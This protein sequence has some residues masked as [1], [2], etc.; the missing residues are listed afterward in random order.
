MPG[1]SIIHPDSFGSLFAELNRRIE[2][3]ELTPSAGN[4]SIT[5][6]ALAVLNS[7]GTAETLVGQY[8]W[9]S[10]PWAG[11]KIYGLVTFGA[12]GHPLLVAGLQP[13]GEYGLGIY[14]D[15]GARAVLLGDQGSGLYGL[16]VRNVDTGTIQQV[17]GVQTATGPGLI[18]GVTASSGSPQDMSTSLTARIGPSGQAIVTISCTVICNGISSGA[19]TVYVNGSATGSAPTVF[20]QEAIIIGGTSYG[21]TTQLSQTR[22]TNCTPNADNVFAMKAYVSSSDPVDF[23]HPVLVVQPL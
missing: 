18:S 20:G 6:G 17:N 11:N 8:E 13:D 5:D 12:T 9:P 22:V 7:S 15:T 1:S 4:Q 2:S 21:M 19:A 10:S 16:G 23:E 14:D 3:L